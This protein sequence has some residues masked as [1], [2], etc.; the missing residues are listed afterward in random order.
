M[1]GIIARV[2]AD[3][4]VD[5][6][7][8]GLE[9]LE[10]RGYDSAGIAVENGAG[11][12]VQKCSGQVNELKE[13]VHDSQIYGGIG[14]GHT[15]WST[16]GPPTD[17][18]AHPHTDSTGEVAVVHNGVID[19]HTEL[20]EELEAEGYEFTSDTDTEVIPHL[21]ER[22]LE[23]HPPEAAFR[24][25]VRDLDG[26]YAI[27]AM[28]EGV[29]A[30]FAARRGSP[31]VLGVSDDEYFLASDV[32][33]FLEHTDEVVY[34]EDDEVGV[35]QP[36]EVELSTL[37]GQSIERS[38]EIV[39]WDPEETG[40]G[41]YDHFM[42]K[43]IENQHV[44]LANSIQGRVGDREPDLDEFPP[45]SFEDIDSVQIVA[46]GTSFH[47]AKYGAQLLNKAGVPAQTFRASEYDDSVPVDDGTLAIAVTQSG[48]TADTLAALDRASAAGARTTAVTNV[49]GSTVAREAD[50]ALF[51]RAG[52][53]I[54]V[55][56][57]KTFSSQVVTLSVLAHRISA[58]VAGTAPWDDPAAF[59]DALERLP[60]HVESVLDTEVAADV[61]DDYLGSDAFFFIGRGLAYPVAI[62]GALKFKEITYEHA[63]GFAAGELKH[64]PLALVT[65][66]TPVF[67]VVTGD[68]DDSTV[69][70]AEEAQTRGA[71]IVAVS[72][73]DH[74]I[75]DVADAHLP[76]PETHPDLAGLLANVQLQLLSYHTADRLGR[77]IDK[78]R[79]LAKSVTVE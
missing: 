36:D 41:G 60:D 59:Y 70:N 57:T 3:D 48:E 46:C 72:T 32:P 6:L 12:A 23:D 42:R 27:A 13:S 28:V 35:I 24:E 19:N 67:T 62:E 68:E 47:A 25:A 37:D 71:P 22:H 74:A 54:G 34:F 5:R 49:V 55:A 1:C 50:D 52:P 58:D 8:G 21:F 26:S 14:I 7:L 17:D 79:N 2:G 38:S 73:D 9:R 51:I 64:G 11:L 63:E 39:S 78:P 45:G 65:P 43:E 20:R 16:H 56:A 69:I 33:A 77:A 40:K 44:S 66:Q 30:V 18:N 76:I 15:R 10:Y 61:A 4:G 29:D 75:T 31:L 53:E